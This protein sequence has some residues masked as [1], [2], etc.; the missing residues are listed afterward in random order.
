MLSNT[1]AIQALSLSNFSNSGVQPDSDKSTSQSMMDKT[2]RA[3][4][5]EVHGSTAESMYVLPGVT[6]QSS[7]NIFT[8]ATSSRGPLAWTSTI[9]FQSYM[10]PAGKTE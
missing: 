2:G 10:M 5:R 1:Y 7:A 6:N 9:R 3:S 4:D 8:A